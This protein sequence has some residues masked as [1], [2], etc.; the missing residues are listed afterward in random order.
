MTYLRSI[1]TY[2]KTNGLYRNSQIVH[3]IHNNITER[4]S[5]FYQFV[6]TR[7]GHWEDGLSARA[8]IYAIHI[9]HQHKAITTDQLDTSM[10]SNMEF[11]K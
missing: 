8:V 3:N 9:I 1:S 5:T 6:D 4:N 11:N 2:L 7:F 10:V